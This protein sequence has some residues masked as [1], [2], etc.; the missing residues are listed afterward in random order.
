MNMGRKSYWDTESI[1]VQPTAAQL[2]KN[3]TDTVKKAK[4]KGKVLHP[5]IIAG[6]RIANSWW[7][8]A[9]C[10]NLERYADYDNRLERGRRYLRTGAVVDLQIEKGKVSA[11]VQGR[12]KTPYKIEIRISPVNEDRC[13]RIMEECGSQIDNLD[14]L[15]KGDFPAEMKEIFLETDGLFPT[16]REISFSCS[17]PDWALMCKHVAA[18]LYGIAVRFDEDP[19]LFF[20]LRGID[21]ER[22][23]QVTLENSVESML[24]NADVKSDRIIYDNDWE[25]LFGLV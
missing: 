22:F 4:A 21:V 11:K 25:E 24:S 5:V 8:G 17:C 20:E 16:P 14:R 23:V 15:L 13:Q 1:Y 10:E 9:W 19:L 3:V 12:K 6:R 2:K 18:V 7:G